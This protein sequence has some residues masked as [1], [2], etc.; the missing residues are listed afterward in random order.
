MKNLEHES[1]YMNDFGSKCLAMYRTSGDI[2][3]VEFA[4]RNYLT[5]S[6]YFAENGMVYYKLAECFFMLRKTKEM[7]NHL[8]Q[9][10][11]FGVTQAQKQLGLYAFNISKTHG[12][13]YFL[14]SVTLLKKVYSEH[15]EALS[16]L[17][18][19]EYLSL[20]QAIV[21]KSEQT[22]QDSDLW[23]ALI[24]SLDEKPYETHY[25]DVENLNTLVSEIKLT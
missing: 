1:K 9:A 25:Y 11:Q 21:R 13:K 22:V 5:S 3:F 17:N 16:N 20:R 14:I 19:Y 10:A 18:R 12:S 4:V 8:I 23:N 6:M 2:R 15:P 7:I 24:E